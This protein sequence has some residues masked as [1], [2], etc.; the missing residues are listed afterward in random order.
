MTVAV[1]LVSLFVILIITIY[2]VAFIQGREISFWPPRIGNQPQKIKI[3]DSAKGSNKENKKPIEQDQNIIQ[4]KLPM[5]K[6]SGR[7]IAEL[8][9]I[10]GV[11]HGTIFHIDS[12]VRDITV[13][14]SPSCDISFPDDMFSISRQHFRIK[15]NPFENNKAAE[16]EYKY[17]LIDSGS[18]NGTFLNGKMV[19]EPCELKSGYVI[20][21]GGTKISFMSH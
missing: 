6:S 21:A 12:G 17:E 14:R 4:S 10:S 5:A 19:H 11:G 13:G 9:I 15:I 20:E 8:I 16:R 18:S 7:P 3:H 1:F 2:L